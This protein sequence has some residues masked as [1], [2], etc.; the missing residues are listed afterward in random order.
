MEKACRQFGIRIA[1]E[2]DLQY[3]VACNFRVPQSPPAKCTARK[4]ELIEAIGAVASAPNK[5]ATDQVRE[6]ADC[7]HDVIIDFRRDGINA[8][9]LSFRRLVPSTQRS[10][11]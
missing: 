7:A 5:K 3:L 2:G 10:R 8:N 6:H 9:I 4:L 11:G 1:V